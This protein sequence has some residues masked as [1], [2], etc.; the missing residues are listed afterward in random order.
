MKTRTWALV[1]WLSVLG[2]ATLLALPPGVLGEDRE[3]KADRQEAAA[4]KKAS[5][6]GKYYQLLKK[7]EVAGDKDNY[8][9]FNDYGHWPGTEYA[10]YQDLPVG[11]WVYVA[12]HWYIWGK[13]GLPA[14]VALLRAS[15]EGK[16]VKLL[17]KIEVVKDE[18]VYGN[19]NDWGH[20]TGT[21]WAGYD[22]L[23]PGHWVYVAP[24]WYI[25]GEKD[26]KAE[27]LLQKASVEGKYVKLLK[28][29]EVA[30]D[31]D[32]YGDF[33]DYGYWEGTAY[34]GFDDLP[35]GY[36]VYVAPHWYI[37]GDTTEK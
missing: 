12:P 16:Y 5:V 10:G 1:G 22:D 15:V 25:W 35:L 28:K 30:Q 33:N 6:E 20:W 19:F 13:E 31:K 26:P 36:W 11:Y 37:W 27:A 34:A 4:L 29:I 7:I 3:K 14:E 18:D 2:V 9:D 23:P 8:G 32:G 17:K 24:H 21:E